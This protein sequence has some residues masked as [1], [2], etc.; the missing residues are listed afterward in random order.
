MPRPAES[1]WRPRLP[2]FEVCI[3]DDP[4][5]SLK[6]ERLL[7][8][9]APDFLVGRCP[10]QPEF[11]ATSRIG[12]RQILVAVA[13][14]HY[15]NLQGRWEDR[16]IRQQPVASFSAGKVPLDQLWFFARTSLYCKPLYV[17]R[18][19]VWEG[20][21]RIAQALL[22]VRV[23]AG[24]TQRELASKLG[25]SHSFVTKVENRVQRVA[26]EDFILWCEAT[27]QDPVEVIR[28]IMN[29]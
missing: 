17:R 9:W 2:Y 20:E 4:D 16:E 24:M 11:L 1:C 29:M 21:P 25:C 22:D 7:A 10:G 19:L 27:A 8:R 18:R 28:L 26:L 15:P 3:Q 12:T 6:P 23:A 13:H 5:A 14:I